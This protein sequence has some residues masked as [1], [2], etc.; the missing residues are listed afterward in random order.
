MSHKTTPANGTLPGLIALQRTNGLVTGG[1]YTQAA[2]LAIN[3]HLIEEA[4]S[5]DLVAERLLVAVCRAEDPASRGDGVWKIETNTGA[6]R[7]MVDRIDCQRVRWCNR[8]PMTVSAGKTMADG[9]AFHIGEL[10]N[11]M[12]ALC[13]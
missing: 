3:A 6:R 4:L 2:A 9:V 12:R 1:V 11:A 7:V 10:R 5:D 13:G 8:Y